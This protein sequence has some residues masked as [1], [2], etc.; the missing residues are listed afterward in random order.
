VH[1]NVLMH[2]ARILFIFGIWVAVLPYLGFPIAMKDGLFTLTGLALA[3]FAYTLYK[4]NHKK[5]IEERI[6]ENFSE[7]RR[8]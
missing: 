2:K 6:F 7:N 5:G 3:F 4:E 8:V 1:Y